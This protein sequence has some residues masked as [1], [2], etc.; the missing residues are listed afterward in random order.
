MLGRMGAWHGSDSRL[1]LRWGGSSRAQAQA[2]RTRLPSW[3]TDGAPRNEGKDVVIGD[4]IGSLPRLIA[5]VSEAGDWQP[6]YGDGQ[7]ARRIV[8]SLTE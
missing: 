3:L 1:V 7:A 6:L 2:G 8:D 5:Q 4:E